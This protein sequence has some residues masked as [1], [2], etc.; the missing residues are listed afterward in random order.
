LSSQEAGQPHKT[1]R[2]FI[3]AK[4][5]AWLIKAVQGIVRAELSLNNKIRLVEDD[6]DVLRNLPEGVGAII[7]SNH[8][9][10]TD[11]RV[12]MEL[13]RRSGKRFI[14]MCN[15]EAFDEGFGLAGW[16]L[17][18]LGH[19]SVE[20][21]AHDVQAKD[22]AV[23]VIKQGQ[24]I[25]VIFPE[26]EIFY[27]NEAVQPFHS[28][29][30]EIGMQAILHHRQTDPNWT[31]Y[32]VPMAIKYHH[33]EPIEG[34]LEKRIA[35]MEARLSLKSTS[36]SLPERLRALQR[37]LIEREG[38][39]HHVKFDAS[40]AQNLTQ[41]IITTQNAILSE[42]EQKLH[43]SPESRRQPI[44]ESWQ[45]SAE[46]K[47]SLE[48]QTDS[49]HKAELLQDIAS[50]E[51]VAQLS[52]W[53]PQYYSDAN[54]SLDRL[55]EAVLKLER[56]LYR[57]KR[58]RQLANRNVFVK[59]AEPIDLGPYFADYLKDPHSVRHN[60]TSQLQAKIQSLIDELAIRPS[61]Q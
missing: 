36:A 37:L 1:K 59:L 25:L 57:I 33:S 5:I 47:D 14:S 7:T 53:K 10:E 27:L 13:S 46:I 19:F 26:G 50:L 49:K 35:K 22:F 45:L 39:M 23:N 56:E 60:I 34:I 54:A 44:D 21:G 9:D 48:Q 38:I 32:L 2:P 28:G 20:R 40:R 42:I 41:E 43:Q 8:A 55:A 31:T 4:P 58:P 24:D 3:P 51:E 6:L 12:C 15:R 52:S 30:I 29:A 18:R 16:A 17:Q 61:Q 11:P